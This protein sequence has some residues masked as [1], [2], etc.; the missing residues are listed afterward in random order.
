MY[1][2]IVEK[3]NLIGKTAEQFA[4]KKVNEYYLFISLYK[5]PQ[6]TCRFYTR[7][8]FNE[9]D[10]NSLD[11]IW[12]LYTDK[13]ALFNNTI[14]KK[15]SLMPLFINLL[16][17]S[18]NDPYTFFGKPLI[19]LSFNQIELFQHGKYFI[20]IFQNAKHQPPPEISNDP[21]KL[22]AWFEGAENVDKVLDSNISGDT[23]KGETVISASSVVGAKTKDYESFGVDDKEHNAMISKLKGKG[24][25]QMT[26][27]I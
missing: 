27:L 6:L 8:D 9:L 4:N 19:N 11:A 14:L 5:D 25:L 26:D 18:N 13:I 24:E 22:I 16:T 2:L 3:N 10:Q 23:A 20:N 17:L 1:S 21:D 12:R 7:D 15:I